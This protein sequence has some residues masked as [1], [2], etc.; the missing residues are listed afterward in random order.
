MLGA[1]FPTAHFPDSPGTAHLCLRDCYFT[2]SGT[3]A[4]GK[5]CSE[6]TGVLKGNKISFHGFIL[7]SGAFHLE[8]P[9]RSSSPE[10][11]LAPALE[12]SQTTL[13]TASHIQAHFQ[14]PEKEEQTI[15]AIKTLQVLP[16]RNT[17]S[18]TQPAPNAGT[19]RCCSHVLLHIPAP[20]RKE[21]MSYLSWE[22]NH[23]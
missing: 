13:L 16:G 17:R 2:G 23:T 3:W 7:S 12:L 8:T 10:E 15:T 11:A 6:T 9:P 20:E 5:N 19:P 1:V 22:M 14:R 21:T 18:Q 4:P